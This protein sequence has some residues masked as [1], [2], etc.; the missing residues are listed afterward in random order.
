M[1]TLTYLGASLLLVGSA[2]AAD[3]TEENAWQRAYPVGT[4][5]PKLF[6]RNVFGNVTVRAGNTREI[7]VAVSER[8]SAPTHAALEESKT[9]LQLRTEATSEGVSF[10]V[11]NPDRHSTRTELCRQCRVEYEI[12]ITVPANAQIDVGTVT[13]G[14]VEVNGVHG[15][16]SARNVNGPVAV[17]GVAQCS[18][19]ESV[20]GALNVSFV[21]APGEDCALKTINGDITL[22][23]PANAGLDAMLSVT[24]GELQ[25]D[26]DIEPLTATPKVEREQRDSGYLYR[27][28]QK[29]GVR[30]G[31]GGPTFTFASLN[32]DVRFVKNK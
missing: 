22:G 23:L 1:K 31:A 7:M 10:V 12:E 11:E 17:A 27:I 9:Q 16:V 18:N 3:V 14:R 13:D 6:V 26:F 28:D 4:A 5:T 2:H 19:I 29:A 8:R 21:R 32:G 30:L 25:S 24:H 20:N 15:A